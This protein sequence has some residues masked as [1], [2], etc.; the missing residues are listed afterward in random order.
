[1]PSTTCMV[2]PLP[3]GVSRALVEYA[4]GRPCGFSDEPLLDAIVAQGKTKNF[5]I[6]ELIQALVASDAFHTK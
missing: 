3:E 5:P 4:L 6:R 1:M 2:D